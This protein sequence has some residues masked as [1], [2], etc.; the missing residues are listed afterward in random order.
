MEAIAK[1][2][3]LRIELWHGVFLLALLLTLGRSKWID[4]NALLIGGVFMGLQLFPAELRRR[5]DVNP[6]SGQSSRQSR[7]SHCWCL[8]L[9]YFLGVLTTLFFR[10]EFGRYFVRPRLFNFD[11]S[12]CFGIRA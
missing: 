11:F 2:T 8:K 6:T 4:S 9:F 3:I 12:D 7:P 10:F 5:M 1:K